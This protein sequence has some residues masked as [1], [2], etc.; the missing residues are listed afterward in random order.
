MFRK[1]TRRAAKAAFAIAIGVPL[2]LGG[3]AL[4]SQSK[5]AKKPTIVV[6]TKNFTEEFILGQLYGQ[7]L[8]AKGYK[9]KIKEN[10]G[11]SEL[12]D[13][14]LTS[15]KINFYPEY[16]GVIV[17]DLAHKKSP[18]TAAATYTAAKK[19]EEKRGYTLLNR[20]PFYDTDA[21]GI[22]TSTA[23][24]YGLKTIPDV[25]K[26]SKTLKYGGFPEC[27]TRTTCFKGL[28][29]IY[30][31]T[32]ISFTPLSGISI[33]TA[34][35]QGTVDAG[36][37]FSTDPQLLSSKYTILTDTKHIF[38]FQNVAPIVSK[39]VVKAGGK[40]FTKTVNAVSAKLTL[41]AMIAMNKAVA[42]DKQSPTKVASAFLKANHL[43]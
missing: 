8:K 32:N 42:I 34:L 37:V 2:V 3:S 1:H 24:Q 27:Q 13:T 19:F 35:D 28:T 4:A 30:G 36:D 39:K 15:G 17:Q 10:I 25:K 11:S 29:D 22:L 40:K 16:M 41:K 43:K 5:A 38:G 18:P 9:V 14:A 26:V 31:L 12:I 20:T 6:G 7:A 21:F 23:K 33:Y